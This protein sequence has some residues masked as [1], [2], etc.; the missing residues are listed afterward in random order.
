MK[1]STPLNLKQNVRT[2]YHL[3][4]APIQINLKF[5][6]KNQESREIL[7]HPLCWNR[8]MP[9]PQHAPLRVSWN[10]TCPLASNISWT[11]VFLHRHQRWK[12]ASTE[13]GERR[14]QIKRQVLQLLLREE[15]QKEAQEVRGNVFMFYQSLVIK[16][17]SITILLLLLEWATS[18]V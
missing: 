4:E 17:R 11:L 10:H 3:R 16:F 8:N 6:F 13:K 15:I 7:F 9:R 2:Q 18:S 5:W 12:A 1:T 14:S